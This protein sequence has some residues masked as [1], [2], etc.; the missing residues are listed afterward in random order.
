M[1]IIECYVENFGKISAQKFSFT[2]G[3]NCIKEDNGSGKTTLATFIKVM[4][5][6]MSDTK[7]TNDY[8]QRMIWVY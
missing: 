2:K 1:K 4:L 6:G 8:C 3:L 5:Y 7:K